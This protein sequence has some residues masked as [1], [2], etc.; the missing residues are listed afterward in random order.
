MTSIVKVLELAGGEWGAVSTQAQA[1]GCWPSSAALVW[2]WK[3][4]LLETLRWA[5]AAVWGPGTI[6]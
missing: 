3:H 4:K 6:A 1:A 2:D 5:A